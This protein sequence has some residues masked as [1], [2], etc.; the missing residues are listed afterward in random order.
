MHWQV[1]EIVRRDFLVKMLLN[2][3]LLLIFDF[4]LEIKI[5]EIDQTD[6]LD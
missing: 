3:I 6:A 2:Y 5:K 4:S 1:D